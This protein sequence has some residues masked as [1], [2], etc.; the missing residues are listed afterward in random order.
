[1]SVEMACGAILEVVWRCL[2][3]VYSYEVYS[4]YEVDDVDDA[5]RSA[6]LPVVRTRLRSCGMAIGALKTS[7]RRNVTS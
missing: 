7:S 3:C 1:V 2:Q 6:I 5:P 4:V